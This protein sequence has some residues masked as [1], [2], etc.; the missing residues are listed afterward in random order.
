MHQLDGATDEHERLTREVKLA[1]EKLNV[2]VKKQEEAR[3]A[4]A[5]DRQKFANVTLV[6]S[7][8]RPYLPSKPNIPMNL[9]AGF[10]VACFFSLGVG[11]TRDMN[12][13]TFDSGDE[14]EST[15]GLPVIA[16]I[17]VKGV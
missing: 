8:V 11:F 3:I 15:L 5:L 2:Y 14:L 6:E 12:R 17:S 4:D 9:A 1:E 10:L 16:T 7:P 13:S